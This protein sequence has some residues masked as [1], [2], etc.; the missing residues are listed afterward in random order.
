MSIVASGR[1]GAA[2][3]QFRAKAVTA[4]GLIAVVI[5]LVAF[6]RVFRS[7]EAEMAAHLYGAGT[8]TAVDFHDAVV[9]FGLGQP[10]GFG[11][12][13]TPECSAALLIV[14]I[15]LVAVGLLARPRVRW[16]RA[17]AGFLAASLVLIVSN[18]LRLGVI[19]WAVNTFGLKSGFEW[20][21]VVVGSVISLAFAVGAMYILVWITA[22]DSAEGRGA[23]N[24]QAGA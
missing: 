6:L 20:S 9:F 3:N 1:H 17:L 21:H 15:A 7:V 4:T 22:R 11:L 18:Q 16:Y 23:A 24:D 2:P 10:G 8:P 12:R 5:V 19:A 13:I 14:P